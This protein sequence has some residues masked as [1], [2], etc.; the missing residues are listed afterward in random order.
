MRVFSSAQIRSLGRDTHAQDFASR[1]TPL[2]RPPCPIAGSAFAEGTFTPEI[3][4]GQSSGK[5]VTDTAPAAARPAFTAA[6]GYELDNGFGVRAMAIGDFNIQTD[7]GPNDYRTF[8]NFLGVQATGNTRSATRWRC[9]P[10][11]AS[12]AAC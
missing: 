6:F 7:F 4:F 8:D 3:G 5:H 11:S 9:A 12:A 1:A 10:A 2:P